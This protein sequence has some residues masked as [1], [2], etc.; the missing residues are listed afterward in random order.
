MKTMSLLMAVIFIALDHFTAKAA[1]IEDLPGGAENAGIISA[2]DSVKAWRTV[3]S[4]KSPHGAPQEYYQK[5]GEGLVVSSKLAGRLGKIL[6]DKDT[7]A[8][9]G[10]DC[11]PMPGVIMSFSKG[12]STLHLYFCFECNI[13]TVSKLQSDGKMASV[14]TYFRPGR[15][16]LLGVVKKIFPEDPQIQSLKESK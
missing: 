3:G 5:S 6:L 9:Q 16:K 13:L 7:Y 1:G 10:P 4:V 11:E 15:A 8:R 2:P 12:N 14:N